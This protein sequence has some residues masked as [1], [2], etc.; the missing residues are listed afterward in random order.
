MR[1]TLS[2]KQRAALVWY[3][4]GK[5]GPGLCAGLMP[6]DFTKQLERCPDKREFIDAYGCYHGKH[7]YFDEPKH[8]YTIAWLAGLVVALLLLVVNS[9]LWLANSLL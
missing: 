6:D 3:K 1:S 9:V 5:A 7:S 8:S 2:A 4:E